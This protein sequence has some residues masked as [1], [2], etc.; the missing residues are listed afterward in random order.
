MNDDERFAAGLRPLP[1]SLDES[2]EGLAASEEAREWF[3]ETF[4]EA[5][6]RFKRSELKAVEGLTEAQICARYAEVY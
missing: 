5:Y 6:V 4:F 2:L 3:G 1:T